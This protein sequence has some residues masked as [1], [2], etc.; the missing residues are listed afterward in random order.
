MATITLE[1]TLGKGEKAVTTAHVFDP[2]D[3]P[4]TF[5]EAAEENKISLMRGGITDLLELTPEQ[6][7]GLTIRHVKQI[8]AAIKEASKLPN[9][10]K[11]PS[12]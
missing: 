10:Q 1:I 9:E 12:T 2:D 7:R 4:L 8:T 11:P 3:M 5:F 6:S